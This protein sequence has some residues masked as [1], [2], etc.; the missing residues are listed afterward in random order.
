MEL[1]KRWVSLALMAAMLVVTAAPT[2]QARFLSPDTW[3]PWQEGVDFNRYGYAGDDPINKSDPNGHVPIIAPGSIP[4]GTWGDA[5]IGLGIGAAAVGAFFAG[6][7][8]AAGYVYVQTSG[9]GAVML[10]TQI[11]A[12]EVG[13]TVPVAAGAGLALGKWTQVAESMSARATAYQ[14]QNGGRAGSALMVNG[15][16]FDGQIGKTLIESKGLGYANLLSYP[17]SKNILDGF[18]KQARSQVAAAD[19]A[20]IQWRFAEKSVA[21]AVQRLFS[22][23]NLSNISVRYVSSN[24][25][26]SKSSSSFS[27]S[28]FFGW[29]K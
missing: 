13:M 20:K 16:K 9:A 2:A 18:L 7:A 23:N 14:V 4:T 21:D 24:N 8:I 15:V 6:P 29:K 3:D 28:S 27:W 26:Q 11:A 17:F 5:A 12:G 25:S 19:G 10:G 22:K 1:L